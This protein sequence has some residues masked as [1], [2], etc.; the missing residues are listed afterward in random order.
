MDGAK[1]DGLP[2]EWVLLEK[3]DG[4][5]LSSLWPSLSGEQKL[6]VAKKI[7]DIVVELK[8]IPL[9]SF[10]Q[11]SS[12]TLIGNLSFTPLQEETCSGHDHTSIPLDESVFHPPGQIHISSILNGPAP[13]SSYTA[14]IRSLLEKEIRSLSTL[15]A[16]PPFNVELHPTLLPRIR[17]LLGRVH[18]DP[19]IATIT[20]NL[21]WNPVFTHGDFAPRNILVL[22]PQDNEDGDVDPLVTVLD[23]EW[24]GF[25]PPHIEW[26]AGLYELLELLSDP[27][28]A[29]LSDE[30]SRITPRDVFLSTLH[31]S[32]V[33]TPF[34]EPKDQWE[35]TM[36]MLRLIEGLDPWW[37]P[38]DISAMNE[39]GRKVAEGK[40]ECVMKDLDELLGFF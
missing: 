34:S 31:S 20:A 7:A 16:P 2:W 18:E 36:K 27:C 5:V 1:G 22:F 8:A 13:T 4:L 26:D 40:R 10:T 19:T 6:R 32:S 30:Q 24:A 11:P 23:W 38:S 3:V 14:Y 29:S 17:E 21:N 35:C 15:S 37:I 9:H 33:V 28:A 12:R 25:F 39:E